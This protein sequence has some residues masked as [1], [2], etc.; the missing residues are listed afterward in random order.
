MC[1]SS[2]LPV[3]VGPHSKRVVNL[4]CGRVRHVNGYKHERALV[5]KIIEEVLNPSIP[6]PFAN[7]HTDLN[8]QIVP[9]LCLELIENTDE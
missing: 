1:I 4:T 8:R 6:Q 2:S 7:N 3:K 5:D 9:T